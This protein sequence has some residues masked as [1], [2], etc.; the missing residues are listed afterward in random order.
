MAFKDAISVLLVCD[1]N[2]AVY[3]VSEN[4]TLVQTYADGTTTVTGNGGGVL[5]TKIDANA[6]VNVTAYVFYDGSAEK[7]YTDNLTNLAKGVG[8]N[9][10][11][12]ATPVN[13][14]NVEVN[15]GNDANAA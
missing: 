4:G 5:A 12:T 9:I 7:V 8:V 1:D 11:F 15:A 10:T 2:W 13:T 6:S 3:K 14:Q